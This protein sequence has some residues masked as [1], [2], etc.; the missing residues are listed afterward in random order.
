LA[1][2]QLQDDDDHLDLMLNAKGQLSDTAEKAEH[3]NIFVTTVC[4]G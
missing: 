1:E 3:F 4:Y 2:T